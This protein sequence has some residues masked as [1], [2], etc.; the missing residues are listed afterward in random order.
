VSD[1]PRCGAP[2]ATPLACGACGAL[3]E[4][5]SAPSPFAIL[6]LA[7]ALEVDALSLRRRLLELAR[8]VHPDYF[9]TAEMSTRARAE[10]ASA[11]LHQAFDTLS[12]ELARADWLIADLGG[13]REGELRDMPKPFLLEVL[14]WNEALEE[15]RAEG[16][17][18]SA[19]ARLHALGSQLGEARDEVLGRLR[20]RLV[21]LPARGSEALREARR[22][23]NALRYLERA[24]EQVEALRLEQAAA[25]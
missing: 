22:E 14:E 18:G 6:G 5:E 13:P 8:L 11:L 12:D 3:L 17:T 2:L 1:C 23:L 24:L 4:V 9:A 10:R 16:A 7:P 25:R 15:A 21:P 20:S 19:R